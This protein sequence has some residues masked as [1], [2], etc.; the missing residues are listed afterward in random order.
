MGTQK[1]ISDYGLLNNI[2]KK[3]NINDISSEILENLLKTIKDYRI[4]A[5]PGTQS[6]DAYVLEIFHLFGFSS[7]RI[8]F[9]LISLSDMQCDGPTLALLFYVKPQKKPIDY[10]NLML[11]ENITSIVNDKMANWLVQTNGFI[12]KIQDLN[13]K[14]NQNGYMLINLEAILN[15]QRSDS[16]FYVKQVFDH[17]LTYQDINKKHISEI[18]FSKKIDLE[19]YSGQYKKS[20]QKIINIIN[21][22]KV[23][24]NIKYWPKET[25]YSAPYKPLLLI[26]FLLEIKHQRKPKLE[27]RHLL[28][29]V[30]GNFDIIWSIV[31]PDIPNNGIASPLLR[32]Q[33]EKLWKITTG[34]GGHLH[35]GSSY[36]DIVDL[37]FSWKLNKEFYD[38]LL[39][40]DSW[41]ILFTTILNKFFDQSV[42]SGVINF[43]VESFDEFSIPLD[44]LNDL[45]GDDEKIECKTGYL[46]LH[47]RPQIPPYNIPSKKDCQGYSYIS[48][49]QLCNIVEFYNRPRRSAVRAFGGDNGEIPVIPSRQTRVSYGHKPWKFVL[50]EE[51]EKYFDEVGIDW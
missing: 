17:I 14:E 23:Q 9:D 31:C 20:L 38:L 30:I 22:L 34:T 46:E 3:R 51:V 6:W 44:F 25:V 49:I 43:I 26:S 41:A 45:L 8:E 47:S 24:K 35:D 21:K 32:L 11:D 13:F 29:S 33:N 27:V 10:S 37:C 15:D 40:N 5:K 42:H 2:Q 28:G 16:F 7:Q 50:L 36:H 18:D 4:F 48:M 12:I 39:E 19:T 1:Y